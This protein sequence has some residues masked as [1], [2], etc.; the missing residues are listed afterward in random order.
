MSDCSSEL[1]VKTLFL[2]LTT[3]LPDERR[4]LPFFCQSKVGSGSPLASH[5]RTAT[6]D[7]DCSISFFSGRVI[8]GG[9]VEKKKQYNLQSKISRTDMLDALVAKLSVMQEY[10]SKTNV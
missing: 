8:S 9:L 5:W 2:L 6:L 7:R 10:I 4:L 1:I 3:T